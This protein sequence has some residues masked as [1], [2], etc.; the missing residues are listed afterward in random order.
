MRKTADE[1][2]ISDWSS[3]VCSSDLLA[4]QAYT[5]TPSF[6]RII[7]E[8]ADEMGVALPRL[9]CALFS[10]EAFT[11]TLQAWFASRGLHGYQAYGRS[12]ERRVGEEWVST[13]RYRWWQY[14]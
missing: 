14:H 12:E 1:V 3:D 8:K 10:G 5:G 2:R 4:P 9:R 7:L 11:P 6:L 13:C